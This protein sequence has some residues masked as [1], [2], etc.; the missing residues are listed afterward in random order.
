MLMLSPPLLT[1]TAVTARVPPNFACCSLGF[2]FSPLVV[3]RKRLYSLV[4]PIN[5]GASPRRPITGRDNTSDRNDAEALTQNKREIPMHCPATISCTLKCFSAKNP[6][7]I[8][9]SSTFVTTNSAMADRSTSIM[10]HNTLVDRWLDK[11]PCY[12]G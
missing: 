8:N 2:W 4:A 9:M 7:K 10:E 1:V 12:A 5:M 6:S 3:R 11:I